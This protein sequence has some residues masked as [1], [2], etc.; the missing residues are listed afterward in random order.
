MNPLKWRKMSWLILVFSGIM[1]ALLVT[2][3]SASDPDCP[4]N[5]ANCDAY[6]AGADVGQGL[7]TVLI[8]VVW[9]IGFL[10]L[11]VIWFMTRPRHRTCP[12]CGNDVKKGRTTCKK[13]D[14]DFSAQSMQPMQNQPWTGQPQTPP[15]P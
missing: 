5:I 7:A 4:P 2:S 6:N 14:F 15:A 1:L 13:C 11:A 3:L 12:R 8:F 10:V 9:L